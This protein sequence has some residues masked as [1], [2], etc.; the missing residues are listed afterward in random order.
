MNIAYRQIKKE[1]KNSVNDLYE[2]LLNDCGCNYGMGYRL[3][4]MVLQ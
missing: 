2:K 3:S 4:G 1:D